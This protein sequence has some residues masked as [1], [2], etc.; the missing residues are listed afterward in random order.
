M[1]S[2][3]MRDVKLGK[4]EVYCGYC[5]GPVTKRGAKMFCSLDCYQAKR[6]T[7]PVEALFWAKVNRTGDCW[8]WTA[9]V[10]NSG[11]GQF[12]VRAGK[13]QRRVVGAHVY[14]YELANGPVPAGLEIMHSCDNPLCV[15]PDHLSV[16]TH[17]ENVRDAS[18]KGRLRVSRPNRHKLTATQVH[19][20]RSLVAAGQLRV[21]VAEHFGI[22]KM[23]VTKIMQGVARPY[24]APL[25]A[26]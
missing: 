14:S 18:A 24:D 21:R 3:K 16:G 5:G 6:L 12:S 1:R 19:E 7:Q 22:S 11:Y 17:T 25:E 4:T 20:I 9:G 23:Y 10:W 8:L 2:H 26:H 13:G 15:R